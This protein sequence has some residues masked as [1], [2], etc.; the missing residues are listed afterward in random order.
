M[1][2]FAFVASSAVP[3]PRARVLPCL[4]LATALFACGSN[5]T[6]TGNTGHGDGDGS[7]D[8][9]KNGNGGEPS[10]D[11][12]TS[13]GDGDSSS[14]GDGD[15]SSHGDGDGDTPTP[16]GPAHAWS[17]DPPGGKSPAEVPQLVAITFDDN[18]GLANEN[19]SGGVDAIVEMFADKTNPKGAG[20]AGDFDGAKAR[21][22]FYYTSIYVV[23]ESEKVLGGKDGEDH[24]GRNRAAWTRAREAGHEVAVHTVNHFNGGVVPLD[25]DDCCR[26][27]D[28]D[29]AGWKDEIGQCRAAL[30]DPANGIG[31]KKSEVIGFR[32]PF[33]GYN[34]ALFDALTSLGFRY[35]TTLPNCFDDTEDGTNCS[36]PY[37]LDQGS[38]DTDALAKKAASPGA[39]FTFEFP[40]VKAHA[41]LW[42]LPP[43]TLILPPDS[44]SEKYGFDKGLR[45]RVKSLPQPLPYPSMFDFKSGKITGLDYTLLIDA[46][47]TGREMGATL[48]YTLDQHLAG[49]RAPFILVAHS[50]LYAYTE[51]DAE[52]PDDD[53]DNPD[54][55]S[56][57]VR[58]ERLAGLKSFLE[59][60]L[61]KPEV[62]VV[63]AEDVLDWMTRNSAQK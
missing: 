12:N 32:T 25:S 6:H 45:E 5:A 18:F 29:V 31:A 42:E 52:A 36:W 59:Y 50:H 4:L 7:G 16:V 46:Q 15:S 44:E 13:S 11:G 33:L 20:N 14:H 27:R 53:K 26:A 22:T 40:K 57:K 47:I 23:D 30:V 62:R 55:P 21:S 54:T 28:F 38:P 56:A 48:K 34:D 1:T 58:D 61:G 35:D 10:D 8:P 39:P 24:L 43:T 63:A 19:A 17:H 49:N 3:S 37:T 9:G 2:L 41:G 60:A 51:G